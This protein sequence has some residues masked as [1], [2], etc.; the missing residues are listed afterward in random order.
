MS[1]A[2]KPQPAGMRWPLVRQMMIQQL[3]GLLA[4]RS[5]GPEGDELSAVVLDAVQALETGQ[6]A[7]AL[8]VLIVVLPERFR[9]G[10]YRVSRVLLSLQAMRDQEEQA[11]A[12]AHVEGIARAAAAAEKPPK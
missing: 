4:I 8:A 6:E 12:R 9:I 10:L 5:S 2:D 7:F 1:S 11:H 3:Q